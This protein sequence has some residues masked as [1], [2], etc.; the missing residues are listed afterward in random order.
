MA[1]K[2][3]IN[4]ELL[5][6]VKGLDASVG[7]IKKALNS[8]QMDESKFGLK[9]LLTEFDKEAKNFS[10]LKPGQEIDLSQSK[11][12]LKSGENIQKIYRTIVAEYGD[13]AKMDVNMAKKLFPDEF[14]T[15]AKKALDLISGF[16]NSSKGIG[17]LESKLDGAKITLEGL[18]AQA[19]FANKA[20]SNIKLGGF[21]DERLKETRDKLR[22]L[23][24]VIPN[25]EQAFRE[26]FNLDSGANIS[27]TF[28]TAQEKE[29]EKL[30]KQF[31]KNL[32]IK[33]KYSQFSNS[34]KTI[35]QLEEERKLL[36]RLKK[37]YSDKKN[38]SNEARIIR[39]DLQKRGIE[40]ANTKVSLEPHISDIENE[41][42]YK[43]ASQSTSSSIEQ[44]LN[45]RRAVIN[46][47]KQQR[48]EQNNLNTSVKNLTKEQTNLLNAERKAAEANQAYDKQKLAVEQLES[49]LS[50]LKSSS[51]ISDTFKALN[52]L[53]ANPEG[54]SATASNLE[55]IKI[56]LQNSDSETVERLKA[57]FAS[58]GLTTEQ[59]EQKIEEL[60]DS[61]N[62]PKGQ[63]QVITQ[64]Q[65]EMQR[66]TSQIQHF[67]SIG[68]QIN[69]LKRAVNSA[70]ST[71][72]ELDATM[73]EAA[74]VTDFS[75]EDMWGKL[76]EYS[77]EASK[78]GA[79]INDLYGATTL[80]YQQ[81]LK[82][83]EAMALGVETMKMARI[84]GMESAEA[85]QAMTAALRGFNMEL[86]ET[87]AERVNDVYSKL[88]A[89]T[90]ADTEQIA[91]AM[92]KTASI[93]A[94]A[95]MEFETTAAFLAQII[96]TTQEAPETAGTA[97]KTI[98][99]RFT[100][101][102][103]LFSKGQLTGEDTEGEEI[104]IN[105]IDAALKTVGISLKDFLNGSKGLDEIF[106]ELASKW[107]SL[108]LATQR[109]IATTAA[110]SRQQSRFIAMMQDYGRTTELVSA[111][112]N[113]AGASQEQFN[114]TMDSL[115]SK[116]N[117]L[118]NAWNNF[119]MGLT[120]N[121]VVKGVVDVLTW[122]LETLNKIIDGMSFGSGAVKMFVSALTSIMAIKGAKGI[123]K[124]FGL[125]I[126][127]ILDILK[128][129]N[130]L[131]GAEGT[132]RAKGM[133]LGNNFMSGWRE[134]FG[135]NSKDGYQNFFK[136]ASVDDFEFT[137]QLF[138]DKAVKVL[139]SDE[140]NKFNAQIQSIKTPADFDKFK[141]DMAQLG[142]N[143]EK[144]AE[145]TKKYNESL[146][147]IPGAL[148]G[149]S[150]G[151]A[152]AGAALLVVSEIM[153]KTGASEKAVETVRA[154]GIAFMSLPVTLNI[155]QT[156]LKT[157]EKTLST[158]K[159]GLIM[160]I[161][162]GIITAVGVLAAA[163]DTPA[164]KVEKLTAAA[165]KASERVDEL[166]SELSDFNSKM[167]ELKTSETELDGLITGTQAW[168]DAL[169]DVNNQ[170]LDIIQ[171]MP[172]LAKYVKIGESGQLM[173]DPEGIEQYKESQEKSLEITQRTAFASNLALDLGKEQELLA[174]LKEDYQPISRLANAT[175]DTR[176]SLMA[177]LNM[178]TFSGD[179]IYEVLR[180]MSSSDY[181]Q[182]IKELESS[183]VSRIWTDLLDEAYNLIQP[184]VQE[185]SSSL[186]SMLLGSDTITEYEYGNAFLETA[187]SSQLL[188]YQE[189]IDKHNNTKNQLIKFYEKETGKEV[190][191]SGRKGLE[192]ILI[193]ANFDEDIVKEMDVEELKSKVESLLLDEKF[194]GPIED[195][196][197]AIENLPEKE[198]E[199]IVAAATENWDNL[200]LGDIK[201]LE[202][203]SLTK[204]LGLDLESF[205]GE[206]PEA[207]KF[208]AEQQGIEVDWNKFKSN[209]EYREQI[210]EQ[211]DTLLTNVIQNVE[212]SYENIR[213]DLR[214]QIG[215][216]VKALF[217][218][219]EQT[220][221]IQEYQNYANALAQVGSIIGESGRN[222]PEEFSGVMQEILAYAGEDADEILG[223]LSGFDFSNPEDVKKFGQYLRDLG[224]P[225]SEAN[226][227]QRELHGIIGEFNAFNPET[228]KEDI[229]KALDFA[230][231]IADREENA[232]SQEEYEAAIAVD[233]D[234]SAF[235]WNGQEWVYLEGT[236]A[237]LAAAVRENTAA[238]AGE[239][240]G[241]LEN[242]VAAGE[243]LSEVFSGMDADQVEDALAEQA[244]AEGFFR[245]LDREGIAE[246]MTQDGQMVSISDLEPAQREALYQFLTDSYNNLI[247]NQ[248]QLDQMTTYQYSTA[249]SGQEMLSMEANDQT[250]IEARSAALQGM[251]QQTG[252]TESER[253]LI[254]QDLIDEGIA[255]GEVNDVLELYKDL[256]NAIAIDSRKLQNA[257]KKLSDTISDNADA[258]KNA[259]E[260][261][262]E[263]QTALANIAAAAQDV[264]GEEV[265]E[266]FVNKYKN[267]FLKLAEGG[268]AA[269]EAFEFLSKQSLGEYLNNIEQ[270][271]RDFDLSID[272][273]Y[274]ALEG[275]PDDIEIGGTFD[276]APII[277]GLM[278][279]GA[280]AE[281][282]KAIL[283]RL[284]YSV[285]FTTRK[286]YVVT[287][288]GGSS[289]LSTSK[290][291]APGFTST[292]TE[293]LDTVKTATYT[294]GSGFGVSSAGG[295]GGGGGSDEEWENP[296]DKLYN[297]LE[298]INEELRE[299]ERIE[300]RYQ[301]LIR[302]SQTSA[303]KLLDL[304]QKETESLLQ[305]Q[306][307][308]NE[309]KEGR[310]AQIE[311]LLANNT[312]LQKYATA[313]KDASTGERLVRID[314][315][316]INAVTDPEEG[317]RIED[318]IS[319]L[320]EWRDSINDA[321][322]ALADI[323]DSLYEIS[324]RGKEQYLDLENRVKE[325]I[326]FGMQEEIDMLGAINESINDTTSKLLDGIQSAIDKER[327][328]R[329]N[330]KTEEEL[331][332]MQRRLAYLRQDTSGANALEVMELEE[333]LREGQQDYTDT[334]I[335]QK[336]S[337][338]QE[339]NDKAAEQREKQIAIMEAQLQYYQDTGAI[340]TDV[341]NLLKD[342]VSMTGGLV[343]GSRLEELLKNGEAWDSLSS[344]QQMDWTEELENTIAQALEFL[345]NNQQL[346]KLDDFSSLKG[347][348]ISFTTADGKTQ[349]G[350][351]GSDGSVKVGNQTYTGVYQG[352]D[353]NYYTA[354]SFKAQTVAAAK[355]TASAPKPAAQQKS[356]PYGKASD[357]T[358][359][360]GKES[361]GNQV[362]AIQYALNQLGYGNEGTK[363]VDG[364]YGDNTFRA[365]AAF[366][367]AMGIPADGIVG[368]DTRAKFRVKQ[369]KTGGLADY[370]GPAWLDGTKSRPELVLNAQDTQNFIQL[371][372]ILA[373]FLHG[374]GGAK[375]SKPMGDSIFDIE[376][377]VDS[378]GNDYDVDQLAERIKYLINE[379]AKYRN[380]NVV[381]LTR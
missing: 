171:T 229:K 311:E 209:D 174:Q 256:I 104:N 72:K 162:A 263:Y 160:G 216:N 168:K 4:A 192:E 63:A 197:S 340:W 90:A 44:E 183:G 100:E 24:K 350:V 297:T 240:R 260:G 172:E 347:T 106:L 323:E 191:A 258:L 362:K 375:A 250:E 329:D 282:T 38:D 43:K 320:E 26:A 82:T 157:F 202:G 366:Q 296:Y 354:E 345:T 228:A 115:E 288:P 189:E 249:Q 314:W 230:D 97:V 306:K 181:T 30:E 381:S 294:G 110:G 35:E 136:N 217:G 107:D 169:E 358:G 132:W 310:Q 281:E 74:V 279:A 147:P 91:T 14:N 290:I 182:A 205:E 113:S 27:N 131:K 342:G 60:K 37:L 246:V 218:D 140:I 298:K 335:D 303:Q 79:T 268:E 86:N 213:W 380:N 276:A 270:I 280:T 221:S 76:P 65:Q 255:V 138:G 377:N 361:S 158:G 135:F 165:E 267:Q 244:G 80:Y 194:V 235:V 23:N 150:I 17:E 265:S 7:Q 220:A 245:A 128:D 239:A 261:S 166:K 127:G 1:N 237:D 36:E 193:N 219:L 241:Q 227:F 149:I 85:T 247:G 287:T 374:F 200:S 152:A 224:W 123:L 66:L 52:Q 201:A 291:D 206:I 45:Q 242:K 93:A 318:Y 137:T 156:A 214:D 368:D 328:D 13:L 125:Q 203:Q 95:N 167:E 233:I 179:D 262:A 225:I 94:S 238:M 2:V 283:E 28:I 204:L 371:K 278:A 41:L 208:F 190:E 173:F 32:E 273:I 379:D 151:G 61:L 88:A 352:L 370:T 195:L 339:Q 145:G 71:I 20:V 186:R 146:K 330:E 360:I 301:N 148:R 33:N 12:L 212:S 77:A 348:E 226:R 309:L 304:S 378:I 83:N 285:E 48:E 299:R 96:E 55:K 133:E 317:Q 336:I 243:W 81:G 264:F 49:Q 207:F 324:Q 47:L 29:L 114:K 302:D 234:P 16:S 210:S 321:N 365:V 18:R 266:E 21:S 116:L 334:L 322:D 272:G 111:A 327:Q 372:D 180:G 312:D 357:T 56:S 356:Y 257:Q 269:Q 211:I 5:T 292:E 129:K 46:L 351:V 69:L 331:A 277:S 92:S 3:V 295:G 307:Y 363:D 184:Y 284:G 122:L 142:L 51:N 333:Q 222:L 10:R 164:E 70:I 161:I 101:V 332:D 305:Q 144:T 364:I 155:V 67:F 223:A 346:E 68:A 293:M 141:A 19:D 232:L 349:K 286:A 259:E 11:E 319:K 198:Q 315:D 75:V 119:L 124:G 112:N 121:E 154:L 130:L 34:S 73:T 271:K 248:G 308:Q 274:S 108:D 231:D 62:D 153:E 78:L 143:V 341:Q 120:N 118:H 15:N 289:F 337:E 42:K 236:M 58:L 376:I 338:L 109:Y 196:I 313:N 353:G 134:V 25:T 6:S 59:A 316:A 187:N 325:A 117:Q 89:I 22:E 53:G 57:H 188:D 175:G 39:E 300:R 326:I 9:K 102:K 185:T 254:A 373:S 170:I 178:P 343:T 31:Q 64:A 253:R 177:A 40:V 99:A 87:S 252:V 54:L 275:L 105:K 8:V 355:P 251:A 103:Q 163:I 367:G 215:P 50:Q 159:I 98:I 199:A 126:P 359:I 139:N 369:Y 84:A 176:N 344:I